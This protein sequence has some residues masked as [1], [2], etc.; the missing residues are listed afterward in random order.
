MVKKYITPE[1]CPVRMIMNNPDLKLKRYNKTFKLNF[2]Y[3]TYDPH[4]RLNNERLELSHTINTNPEYVEH[5]FCRAYQKND[6]IITESVVAKD[7]N[8]L[9]FIIRITFQHSRSSNTY[10]YYFTDNGI[11][12]SRGFFYPMGHCLNKYFLSVVIE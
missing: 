8:I 2:E 12:D 7:S 4:L 9:E 5:Y 1:V 11:T 10:I 3:T 6:W